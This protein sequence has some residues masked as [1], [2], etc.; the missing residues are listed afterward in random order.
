MT[1]INKTILI[2][3]G[4]KELHWGFPPELF[5]ALKSKEPWVKLPHLHINY[6]VNRSLHSFT[7]KNENGN[8]LTLFKNG[9]WLINNLKEAQT[10]LLK[11]EI[12]FVRQL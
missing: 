1:K 9:K 10:S 5:F 8:N 12:E 11:Q 4:W 6:K 7:Y 2:Q 3:R